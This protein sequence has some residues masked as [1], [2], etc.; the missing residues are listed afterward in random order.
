MILH[1]VFL[2]KVL[3]L[4]SRHKVAAGSCHLENKLVGLSKLNYLVSCGILLCPLWFVS[5]GKKNI[6][7]C[8]VCVYVC[9]VCAFVCVRA[10]VCVVYSC[11]FTLHF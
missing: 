11:I 10:C 6:V 9:F 8:F 2:I 3:D 4:F 5:T 7:F 1:Y